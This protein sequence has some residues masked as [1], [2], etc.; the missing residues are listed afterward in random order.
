MDDVRLPPLALASLGAARDAKGRDGERRAQRARLIKSNA[1]DNGPVEAAGT[2]NIKRS[3]AE[4]EREKKCKYLSSRVPQK[5]FI[6]TK[7][8]KSEVKRQAR[9]K[10]K[11]KKRRIYR[12]Y[13]RM[14][15]PLRLQPSSQCAP[16]FSFAFRRSL[17]SRVHFGRFV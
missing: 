1:I 17:R 14:L 3:E 11:R 9:E 16:R 12:V 2:K 8:E 6:H 15:L 4:R 10:K 13:G 7:R 5:L